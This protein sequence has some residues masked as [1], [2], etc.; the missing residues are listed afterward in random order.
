METKT[1]LN[2]KIHGEGELISPNMHRVVVYLYNPARKDSL[3]G[4]GSKDFRTT[5]TFKDVMTIDEAL[6]ILKQFEECRGDGSVN[7]GKIKKAFYNGKLVISDGKFLSE[8][9]KR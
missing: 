6:I 9:N 7:C 2:R 1:K 5:Y 3:T 8:F 4:K